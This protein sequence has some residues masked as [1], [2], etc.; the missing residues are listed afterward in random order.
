MNPAEQQ[1]QRVT[2]QYNKFL[3]D[4]P[5]LL[6]TIPNRWIIYLDGEKGHYDDEQTAH[7]EAI[8]RYDLDIGF[9]IVQVKNPLTA[10]CRPEFYISR[11]HPALLRTVLEEVSSEKMYQELKDERDVLIARNEQ[12]ELFYN[13][14][15]SK[16]R[17]AM[18]QPPKINT[19]TQDRKNR[20][21]RW[22][23]DLIAR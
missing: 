8:Q 18:A 16:M 22:L 6:D 14:T 2:V 21:L 5:H 3:K 9:I 13:T 20:L 7:S 12:L 17:A 15:M 11:Y 23:Y 4:L 10:L 19:I 1:L